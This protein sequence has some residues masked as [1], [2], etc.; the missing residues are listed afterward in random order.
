ME[1][2]LIPHTSLRVSRLCAGTMGLGGG[3]AAGVELTAE[4]DRQAR[5]HLDAALALGINFFD[6]ANIYGRGRAETLFGRVMRERPG[7]RDT[8]VIQSKCGIRWAD[9]PAGNSVAV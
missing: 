8:I 7:L 2:L 9:D 4:H 6:H 5:Q 3:W 1:K